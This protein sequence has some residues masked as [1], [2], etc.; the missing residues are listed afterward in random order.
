MDE[1][2]EILL[3]SAYLPNIQYFSKLLSGEKVTIEVHD[4]Y[5]KQSFRNRTVILSANGPL[6]LVIPVIK[7]NGNNTKTRDILIDCE[8][9]WQ[10]LHWRAIVSAY[11]HSPFFEIFE[12]E[13]QP[14]FLKKEKYLLDWNFLV[15]NQILMI[16]GIECFYAKTDAFIHPKNITILDYRD[17]IHPKARMQKDDP[18]FEQKTYSQVFKS[19]FGFIPNLSFIDLLFNEGSEAEFIC[20][21]CIK[22]GQ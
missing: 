8:P 16:S 17:I 13:L 7:P 21:R 15:L 10:H 20:K 22:K 12:K 14:I 18:D 3:S 5:Q 2:P 4:N 6:N 1:N 9:P 11:K 19:K